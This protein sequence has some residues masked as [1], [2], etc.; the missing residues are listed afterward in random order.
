MTGA[1]D[2]STKEEDERRIKKIL[3]RDFT[4][5]TVAL[6]A[7]S[8]M[9]YI[10]MNAGDASL[11]GGEADERGIVD[12]GYIATTG[13]NRWLKKHRDWNDLFALLNTL[14]L[15]VPGVYTIHITLWLGDYDLA[16]RYFATHILRSL[17]GWFTY[18]PSSSEYLMSY[19][20]VPDIWQCLLKDCGDPA[21]EEVQP[22][23]SFFSGHVATMICCANHMYMNGHKNWGL[24][25]HVLNALQV[26]RM[27]AT[28]GHYSIDMI[29]AWFVAVYVSRPAGRLGRYFSRGKTLSDIQPKDATEAFEKLI[30]VE[31]ERRSRRMSRLEKK[32]ELQSILKEMEGEELDILKE[33][34]MQT[35]AQLAAEGKLYGSAQDSEK[36]KKS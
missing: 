31:E 32:E 33:S 7:S 21:E 1:A 22:F 28:R 17:C 12:T 27:L 11:R 5:L 15:L 10:E 4:F 34:V 26:V 20:D 19:Y 13:M 8:V 30:G 9:S 6:V 36:S 23:V 16:F 35:T 2:L 18:L 24:V 14:A 29:I 25:C 3:R